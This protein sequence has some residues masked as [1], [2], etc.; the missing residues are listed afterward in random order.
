MYGIVF[1]YCDGKRKLSRTYDGI[2]KARTVAWAEFHKRPTARRVYITENTRSGIKYLEYYDS[3]S[4]WEKDKV[5]GYTDTKRGTE[6][7]YVNIWT[8]KEFDSMPA[9]MHDAWSW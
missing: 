5:K 7:F 2:E 6:Y 1:E 8:G 9:Y 3:Y 4:F